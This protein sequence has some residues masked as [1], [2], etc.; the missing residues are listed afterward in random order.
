MPAW[1][2]ASP[3][4]PTLCPHRLYPLSRGSV[5]DGEL[6]CAYH[7]WQFDGTGTCTFIPSLNPGTPITSRTQLTRPFGLVERFGAIWMA[8]EAPRTPFVDFT[9]WDDTS[10]D[11]RID[12]PVRTT[13]S[14]FQAVDNFCDTSHFI[15]V[16]AGTFGGGGTELVHPRAV[17]RDGWT[18]TGTYDAPYTVLD[19]PRVLSGELPSVQPTVQS[20]TY[21]PATTM[22]LRMH[23]PLTRSTFT[24]LLSCQP[25]TRGSTR[26]YRWWARD[27]I[28]GDEVRW[29]DCLAV[30]KAVM[31]EDVTTFDGYLDDRVPLDLTQ[32][33]HV[34]ADK[35]SLGY[36]R[37]LADLIE[38]RDAYDP[39]DDP[40]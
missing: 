36:R 31:D 39:D 29:A 40:G 16:H 6:R 23:F 14:A 32:E 37:I 25:E 33:V 11:A 22:L 26:I 17:E 9:E 34:P 28:V 35:L 19:D 38:C 5:V 7:A 12:T 2:T 15:S 1:P 3:R 27:D 4:S 8:P 21:W 20:K 10:F 30:E 24:V 13:A 18:V